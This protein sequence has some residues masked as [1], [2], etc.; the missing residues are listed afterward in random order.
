MVFL[1]IIS[2]KQA[3]GYLRNN[4]RFLKFSAIETAIYRSSYILQL[5]LTF[6]QNVG[7][8]VMFGYMLRTSYRLLFGGGISRFQFT[9]IHISLHYLETSSF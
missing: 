5:F 1:F 7:V 8:E 2:S 4:V 6:T 3:V 9:V